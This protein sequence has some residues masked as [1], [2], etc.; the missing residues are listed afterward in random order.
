MAEMKHIKLQAQKRRAKLL[1]DITRLGWTVT[2][3]ADKHG[4]TRARMSKQ[5]IMARKERAAVV[6]DGA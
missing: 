4:V 2:K 3:F 1:A 6:M 5:L